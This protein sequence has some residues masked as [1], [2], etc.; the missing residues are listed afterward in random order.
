MD[1]GTKAVMAK[2]VVIEITIIVVI[3]SQIQ[4]VKSL[5]DV[6]IENSIAFKSLLKRFMMRPMGVDSKNCM[7]LVKIDLSIELW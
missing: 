5:N 7:L 4:N 3:P 2:G 6:G 1:I